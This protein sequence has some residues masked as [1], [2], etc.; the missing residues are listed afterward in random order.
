[1]LH[2]QV[3]PSC[4]GS[5]AN[6]KGN[7]KKEEMETCKKQGKECSAIFW[8]PQIKEK[9]N[10]NHQKGGKVVSSNMVV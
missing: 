4:I 6:E 3:T 1:M 9:Q 5:G 10:Q 8:K 2:L 7:L